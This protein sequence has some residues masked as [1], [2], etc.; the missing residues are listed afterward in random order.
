MVLPWHREQW[1]RLL[2]RRDS[3]H[4]GLLITGQPGIGKSEFALSLCKYL[5]CKEAL[6]KTG[7]FCDGCQGCRLFDAGT[8]PDMHVLTTELES[9]EGRSGLIASYSDRYLDP[10]EREKRAKPARVISVDQI[11]QLIER[12]STHG[13]ISNYRVALIYPADTMN[14]NA[15]NAL[16]K[17]LEEPPDDATLLLVSA[18]PGRLPATVRSRCTA[19][20]LP[21]P[22]RDQALEWISDRIPPELQPA[23]LQV[24]RGSPLKAIALAESGFLEAM[25]DFHT[26]LCGIV[27]GEVEAVDVASRLAKTDFENSLHWLQIFVAELAAW[28]GAGK[29]PGWSQPIDFSINKISV[30]RIYMLYDKITGYRRSARSAGNEQLVLEDILLNLG[31]LAQNS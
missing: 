27:E 14:L 1:D 23:A 5:L 9:M 19:I 16:L 20:Q 31:K 26:K 24:A 17:L 7:G 21:L 3:L 25:R 6:K 29:A 22:D 8:H 30:D 28:R 2:G 11:R 13:H 15:A 10:R 12:F 4:H 18:E